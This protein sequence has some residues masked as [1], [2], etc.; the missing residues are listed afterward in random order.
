MTRCQATHSD[1]RQCLLCADH[2]GN[3]LILPLE[4]SLLSAAYERVHQ[5]LSDWPRETVDR[6]LGDEV[7]GIMQRKSEGLT[8]DEKMRFAVEWYESAMLGSLQPDECA[9]EA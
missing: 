9:G 2:K 6:L 5:E 4:P 7:L 3:H 1:G 8:L